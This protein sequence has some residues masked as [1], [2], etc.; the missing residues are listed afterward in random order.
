MERRDM[1]VGRRRRKEGEEKGE[2]RIVFSSMVLLLRATKT[3]IDAYPLVDLYLKYDYEREEN[4][5]GKV[6]GG[7]AG[8]GREGG[9]KGE[10]AR[11]VRLRGLPLSFVFV[12]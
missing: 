10:L 8:G 6:E 2:G 3:R 12:R 11:F 9:S 7:D 4:D 5:L 1:A